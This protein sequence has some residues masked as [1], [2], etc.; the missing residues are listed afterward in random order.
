MRNYEFLGIGSYLMF[1]C[2][3]TF[4]D[5]RFLSVGCL[6]PSR[7]WRTRSLHHRSLLQHA[8]RLTSTFVYR[9]LCQIACAHLPSPTSALFSCRKFDFCFVDEA[10]QFTLPTC[11]GP[12]RFADKFVSVEDHFQLSPLVSF[13]C[14]I[15]VFPYA[16]PGPQFR[17]AERRFGNFSLPPPFRSTPT[18]GGRSHI[19]IPHESSGKPPST[20]TICLIP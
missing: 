11:L 8:C 12:L 3:L 13:F 15:S 4:A 16:Y 1:R 18:R 10:S 5:L 6:R 17:Y 14:R 20:F 7:N 2:I 9:C 19:S